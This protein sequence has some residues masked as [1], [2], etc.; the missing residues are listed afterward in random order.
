LAL[1]YFDLGTR[2]SIFLCKIWNFVDIHTLQAP[3]D[4]KRVNIGKMPM[5]GLITVVYPA[6]QLALFCIEVPRSSPNPGRWWLPMR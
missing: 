2:G 4:K 5:T 1:L 6:D 3:K